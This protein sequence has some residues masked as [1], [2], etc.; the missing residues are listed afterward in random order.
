MTL[1][2]VWDGRRTSKSVSGRAPGAI[3]VHPLSL[4]V[5]SVSFWLLEK[6]LVPLLLVFHSRHCMSRD[7]K[8][9]CKCESN[10]KHVHTLCHMVWGTDQ[11]EELLG[12][13]IERAKF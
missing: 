7:C 8:R 10:E 6:F 2:G 13:K 11:R 4:R 5:Y 9:G 1:M 12:L 3:W